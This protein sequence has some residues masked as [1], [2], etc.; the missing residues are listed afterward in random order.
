VL[1]EKRGGRWFEPG[2]DEPV[3]LHASCSP[4]RYVG[5]RLYAEILPD[6]G[7]AGWPA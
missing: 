4:G 7:G 1:R 3:R 5:D 6:E 2:S